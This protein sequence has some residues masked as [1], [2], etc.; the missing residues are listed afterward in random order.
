M[1]FEQT[2]K[3]LKK[4]AKKEQQDREEQLKEK[5]KEI[6][7]VEALLNT[8]GDDSI[9]NDFLEGRNG[10]NQLTKQEIELLD[11]FHKLAC[12]TEFSKTIENDVNDSADHLLSLIESKNK[13][14]LTTTY[15]DLKKIFDRVITSSYWTNEKEKEKVAAEKQ[16][17]EPQQAVEEEIEQKSI[18]FLF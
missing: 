9:R 13:A 17:D 10:A 12:S 18:I 7:R 5:V 16:V 15:G 3:A 14:V 4:Q 1:N 11:D 6:R 2:M 8:L